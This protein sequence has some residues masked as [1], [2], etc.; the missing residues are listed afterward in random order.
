MTDARYRLRYVF[1]SLGLILGFFGLG[2]L[3]TGGWD[4]LLGLP[5]LYGAFLL[6]RETKRQVDR[7]FDGTL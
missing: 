1:A 5:L 7:E 4:G 3:F 2:M 6:I